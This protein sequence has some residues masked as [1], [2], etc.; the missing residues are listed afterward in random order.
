MD[1][2]EPIQT[3]EAD[4]HRSL[5]EKTLQSGAAIFVERWRE[6][7]PKNTFRVDDFVKFLNEKLGEPISLNSDEE[8]ILVAYFTATAH[9]I[10]S[11]S[12]DG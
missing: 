12:R 6:R 5:S 3:S 7:S 8:A 1:S 2:D 10:R 9:Q 11:T 4:T